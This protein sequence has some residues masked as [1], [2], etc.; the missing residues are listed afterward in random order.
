LQNTNLLK[1]WI[2][3]LFCSVELAFGQSTFNKIYTE[4]SLT[5]NMVANGEDMVMAAFSTSNT[6]QG[7]IRWLQINSVGTIVKEDSVLL[8]NGEILTTGYRGSLQVKPNGNY[9]LV[10]FTLTDAFILEVTSQFDSVR[11]RRYNYPN[12]YRSFIFGSVICANGDIAITG[13]QLFYPNGD[14]IFQ[15]GSLVARFDSTLALRWQLYDSIP[16]TN[17]RTE[18]IEQIGGFIIE[19]PDSS[20]IVAG[21]RYSDHYRDSSTT[22]LFRYDVHGNLVWKKSIGNPNKEDGSAVLLKSTD[23][24]FYVAYSQG[25]GRF[26]FG[27]MN[28]GKRILT[29]AEYS[30]D[31]HLMWEKFYGKSGVRKNIQAMKQTGSSLI[32]LSGEQDSVNFDYYTSTN[33]ISL[34]GDS[35]WHVER[36]E[37]NQPALFVSLLYDFAITANGSLIMGGTTE[38][39]RGPRYFKFIWCVRTDSIGCVTPGCHNIGLEEPNALAKVSVYPNPANEFITI[40]LSSALFNNSRYTVEISDVSGRMVLTHWTEGRKTQVS[41]SQLN[42]GMYIITVS[43]SEAILVTQ[44]ILVNRQ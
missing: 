44:K 34:T 39:S 26:I 42:P 13:E 38:Y 27:S 29:L 28:F 21:T 41:T 10:G 19:M 7:C 2:V 33:G 15:R 23:T 31:G 18:N 24:S 11:S 6:G 16:R 20:V 4:G 37:A 22:V 8:P 43:S 32:L 36:Y 5:T 3:L 25:T 40:D 1:S 14:T 35:L 17:V 30:V 9:V 12:R